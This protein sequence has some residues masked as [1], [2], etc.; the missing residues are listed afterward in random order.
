M[1]TIVVPLPDT[2]KDKLDIMRARGYTINGF[3]RAVLTRALADTVAAKG[4]AVVRYRKPGGR[5][6]RRTVPARLL[7]ATVLKLEDQG[8][9]LTAEEVDVDERVAKWWT[10]NRR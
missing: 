7:E 4:Q 8:A 3:V 1:K 9:E 2:L 5:W 6:Q 10:E